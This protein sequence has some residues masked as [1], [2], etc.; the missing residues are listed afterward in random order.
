MT[1]RSFAA[2]GFIALAII[3][4]ISEPCLSAAVKLKTSGVYV[5]SAGGQH[6]WNV[7]DAHTLLW[8]G[9]PYVPVGCVVVPSS[10]LIG[11]TD[12]NYQADVKT[13]EAIKAK[14]ITDVL[15]RSPTPITST[16]PTAWQKIIDYLDANG[17][18]YGIEMNDGPK[19][20][21]RGYLISP[22]RYRL[23]GPIPDTKITCNWPFVDS[24]IYIVVN[25]FDNSI[26]TT[27]GAVV[28]DGKVTISLTDP[29]T[30]GQVLVVYPR[31]SFK[32][33]AEGGIGDIWSGFG[34][35]RDRVIEFFG[36]LKLGPGM[37]FFLEPFT[38]KMDFT[39]EMVGFLPDSNGFRLGLE[40]YLTKKYVHEGSLNAG[41]G[42][43]DNLGSIEEAVRLMPLWN[44]GR[45]V[46][47]VYDR[48]S[49]KLIS[50]DP[51]VTR[52][53]R[54]V[55]DY[56]DTSAQEYMNTIADTLRKQIANVPVIFKSSKYHRI[57]A[58]PYGMGG[59]DGLAVDNPTVKIAGPVYSLAEESGKSTW[60][61]AVGGV[62]NQNENSV[63]STLDSLR[64]IGCKGFFIDCQS[65]IDWCAEFKEKIKPAAIAEFKPTVVSY[66]VVPNTGASVKRLARD[67]WWLPTLRTGSVSYIG[68]G[69]FAY[70]IVGEDKTYL[71]SSIGQKSVTLKAGPMG[72]PSVEFPRGASIS[73]KKGGFF[74]V[75]LTDIPTVL[76]GMNIALVFPVETA[77]LEIDRLASAILEADKAGLGVSEVRRNLDRAKNVLKNGQALVAYGIAQQSLL[78][79][80]V[81]LGA[82]VWL[83]GEQSQAN[84]FDGTYPMEGAS[85]NLVLLLD[86]DEEA[87]LMTYTA[88]FT[89]DAPSNSSYEI[90]IA[91]TPP[92]EGSPMAYS[93]EDS[94]WT[95]VAAEKMQNYAPGL[96]WYKIGTANLGPGKHTLKLRAEGRRPQDGRYYFAVDAVVFSPRGFS[97]NGVIKPY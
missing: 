28:R 71:W 96:A 66:P 41:W 75:T 29:L 76:R 4:S 13:L 27:G 95:P 18:C 9:Q 72:Y 2:V 80:L 25:K 48:A 60:F 81:R 90:W 49:A 77:Q 82:D 31:K 38:S 74:S 91:G 88:A 58:N 51:S 7:N 15:L 10:V 19:Q 78:E 92:A 3:V 44:M 55:L 65:Q 37:R 52:L 35:Y 54:D 94:P 93:I 64:E 6:P 26:K 16:D 17:F 87:P 85:G 24:A 57:Y 69:L 30:S 50:V 68:D 70:T 34:E 86:T 73:K 45:G 89:F 40:A 12:E 1:K 62:S 83:E 97:P 36:K 33:V 23:E 43:N 22:N 84:N 39:G 5:D 8:D 11:S 46:P 56:R 14:G 21:L 53:W 20:P 42:L 63:M 59:F 79:L 47:Y 32:A 67:T 61:I